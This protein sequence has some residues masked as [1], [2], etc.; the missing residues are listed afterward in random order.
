MGRPH[1]VRETVSHNR[2]EIHRNAKLVEFF[3]DVKGICV[4]PKRSQQLGT[5]GNNLR[6]HDLCTNDL[7]TND[8]CIHSS[9][10]N[11]RKAL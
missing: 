7:C 10:L 6:I 4:L 2:L 8:L 1:Q 9:S 3:G 5:D 11:E